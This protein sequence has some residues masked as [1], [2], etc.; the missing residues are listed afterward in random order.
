MSKGGMIPILC[1]TLLLIGFQNCGG[2]LGTDTGN[3][4]NTDAV[5]FD[6]FGG[7]ITTE[8]QALAH[9]LC[10]TSKACFPAI[11]LSL[12]YSQV[13]QQSG[14]L[15]F[16]GVEGTYAEGSLRDAERLER[17]GQLNPSRSRSDE[18]QSAISSLPC[19]DRGLSH[20]NEV[21]MAARSEAIRELLQ[22]DP[23][24]ALI[25]DSSTR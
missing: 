2:I 22:E 9:A 18:C 20:L 3:P 17:S 13:M 10:T 23:A 7:P 11:D 14:V 19:T 21:P 5:S 1:G 15:G 25:Y 12:C 16:V 24:C 8:A 4:L 6:E